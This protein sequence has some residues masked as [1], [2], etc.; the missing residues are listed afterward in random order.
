MEQSTYDRRDFLKVAGASAALGTMM[1]CGRGQDAV[2]VRAVDRP[3]SAADL[4]F[5]SATDLAALIRTRK[6]SAREVMTAHLDRINRVNP[7]ITAIVAKLD[8]ERCLALADVADQRV[9]RGESLPPLL[10]LPMAFKDLQPAV[11]FPWTRG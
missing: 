2:P 7:K 4:C 11:G 9:A 6:V 8:D 3:A 10:G 5:R 1:A